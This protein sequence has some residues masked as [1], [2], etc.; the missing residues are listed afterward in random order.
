MICTPGVQVS[1][2]HPWVQVS[3]LHPG[4]QVKF[5]LILFLIF[6]IK[7]QA[8]DDKLAS[9]IGLSN[10]PEKASEPAP[11]FSFTFFDIDKNSKYFVKSKSSS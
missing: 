6:I 8:Y 3:D 1:D 11:A 7:M 9:F 2:L 5:S 4:V 10:F